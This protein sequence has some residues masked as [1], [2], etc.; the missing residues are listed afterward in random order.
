MRK[1]LSFII[2]SLLF[3][4][5]LIAQEVNDEKLVYEIAKL[6]E[7]TTILRYK[8]ITARKNYFANL[9]RAHDSLY[10]K[11][12]NHKIDQNY[13]LEDLN[14]EKEIEAELTFVKTHLS[15]SLSL[16]ILNDKI[17]R[18]AAIK[19][20]DQFNAVFKKMPSEIQNSENGKIL[21][22]ILKIQKNSATGAIASDFSFEDIKGNK[23]SLS[24]IY[25]SKKL[26]LIYFWASWNGNCLDELKNL[27]QINNKYNTNDFE[28]IGISEDKDFDIWKKSI[29]K[30]G[31]QDWLHTNR[32]T[33]PTDFE[34]LYFRNAIPTTILINNEGKIIGRWRGSGKENLLN[35]EKTIDS[36]FISKHS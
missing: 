31:I 32:T 29:Q 36:Y 7:E 26:V 11:E 16:K 3:I 30:Y 19:Y 20:Y 22:S 23:G 18:Y 25:E 10:I 1:L 5:N 9:R 12:L 34:K 14:D 4:S 35:I 15:S 2:V 8:L 13:I 17:K 28:I 27:K 33:N 21:D 6:R 24:S